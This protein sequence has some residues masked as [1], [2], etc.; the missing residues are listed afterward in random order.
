MT[1]LAV[2]IA[3]AE[4]C[5]CAS[6][7]P[8]HRAKASPSASV[9]AQGA[10]RVREANI[11]TSSSDDTG[12][13]PLDDAYAAR[14]G[15][16]GRVR[17]PHA[18]AVLDHA[19]NTVETLGER[20]RIGDPLECGIENPVPAVRDESVAILGAP[21]QGRPGATDSRGRGLDRAPRRAQSERHHLDRQREAAER[22][23]PL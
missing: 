17:E 22:G 16:H 4:G 2:A 10:L 19:C 8:M 6:A 12:S 14:A 20:L 7:A 23:H 3:L 11:K 1:S 15:K 9:A 13:T 21:Q 5:C 18:Q